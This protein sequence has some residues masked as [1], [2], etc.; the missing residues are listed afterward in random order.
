LINV[1][2][3][4]QW[5]DNVWYD[6][7][8]QNDSLLNDLA[9]Y[10]IVT[11]GGQTGTASITRNGLTMYNA[12]PN[13]AKNET[14]IRFSLSS[15]AKATIQILDMSGKTVKASVS[16]DYAQGEHVV[17]VSLNGLANGNYMYLITTSQGAGMAGKIVLGN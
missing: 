13:P 17:P 2:N 4:T 9:I 5:S 14:N 12:F 10:P 11:I 15:A 8:S 16:Q 1:Q 7:Y 6:N 3:A